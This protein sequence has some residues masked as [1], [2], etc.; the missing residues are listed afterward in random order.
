M[1]KNLSGTSIEAVESKVNYVVGPVLLEANVDFIL[2]VDE[3]MLAWI[4]VVVETVPVVDICCVVAAV[5]GLLVLVASVLVGAAV[6]LVS[7][8][9]FWHLLLEADVYMCS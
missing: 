8:E 5:D 3:S 7:A 1:M 4:V 9:L 6:F 2:V